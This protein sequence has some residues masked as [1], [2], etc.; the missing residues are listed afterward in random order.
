MC[1]CGTSFDDARMTGVAG[2]LGSDITG[3]ACG[4]RSGAY[5][6]I[7][8]AILAQLHHL[9]LKLASFGF[10]TAETKVRSRKQKGGF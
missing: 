1:F 6:L 4:K 7:V 9:H 5:H 8:S 2:H 3:T 10:E